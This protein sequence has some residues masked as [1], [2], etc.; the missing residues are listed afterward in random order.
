[1]GVPGPMIP[2]LLWLLPLVTKDSDWATG[3]DSYLEIGNL[4]PGSMQWVVTMGLGFG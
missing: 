1:V 2:M 3:F 4:F